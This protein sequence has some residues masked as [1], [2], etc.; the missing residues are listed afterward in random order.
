MFYLSSPSSCPA[1]TV[2]IAGVTIKQGIRMRLFFFFFYQK[3]ILIVFYQNAV[4][5][6]KEHKGVEKVRV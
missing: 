3:V 2:F 6:K 5:T 4:E 1:L